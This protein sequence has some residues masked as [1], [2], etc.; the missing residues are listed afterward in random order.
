M[1][2]SRSGESGT[3][4]TAG[5]LIFSGRPDP[6]WPLSEATV[7][8]LLDLWA[9]LEPLPRAVDEPARLG[10]RGSF[11]RGPVSEAWLAFANTVTFRSPSG[12]E[13]RRDAQGKFEAILLRSA[14]AGALPD[15]PALGTPHTKGEAE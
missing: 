13:S 10:Y 7:R 8:D 15:D 6:T 2:M 5:A 14:P 3:A 4:W 12:A 11:L 9:I 1:D